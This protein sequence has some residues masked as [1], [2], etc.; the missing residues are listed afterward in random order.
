[1]KARVHNPASGHYMAYGGRGIR[2]CAE[3]DA[4]F[5]AFR[6][7]ALK[8]GYDPEAAFGEC[9]IDRIDVNGNYEPNNCRWVD[10]KV[11]AQN[12]RKAVRKCRQDTI[13]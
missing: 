1:M 12:K 5:E 7:W 13:R 10:L 8:S 11:Q 3:W 2:I 9:T 4:S 6:D